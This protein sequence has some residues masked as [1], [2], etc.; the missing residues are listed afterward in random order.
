MIDI[1]GP[2]H[3]EWLRPLGR[4]EIYRSKLVSS[5][6]P[7]LLPVFLPQF[8]P[9]FSS[10][11]LWSGRI[12]QVKPFLPELLWLGHSSPATRRETKTPSVTLE[13]GSLID[14]GTCVLARLA[15]YQAPRISLFPSLKEGF[16]NENDHTHFFKCNCWGFE[17]KSVCPHCKH[18]EGTFENHFGNAT[19]GWGVAPG[20]THP[21]SIALRAI[22]LLVL[23]H[24]YELH[25][26]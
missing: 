6:P 20:D 22:I 8:L 23:P 19:P 25:M 9:W 15:G 3:S 24:C 1:G 21:L 4:W 17:L 16:A 7:W 13:K 5:C 26:F 11:S 12:S 10:N 14:P 18:S 2:V